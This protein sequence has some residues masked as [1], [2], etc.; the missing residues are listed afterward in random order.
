MIN[1]QSKSKENPNPLRYLVLPH[2]T[3]RPGCCL[4]AVCQEVKENWILSVLSAPPEGRGLM[5]LKQNPCPTK[6]VIQ[7][8]SACQGTFPFPGYCRQ[9]G[10]CCPSVWGAGWCPTPLL[11]YF[12][13]TAR[14]GTEQQISFLSVISGNHPWDPHSLPRMHQETT[15]ESHTPSPVWSQKWRTGGLMTQLCQQNNWAVSSVERQ[16]WS[17]IAIASSVSALKWLLSI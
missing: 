2:L 9:K 3:V 1:L 17:Q 12:S 11:L 14:Y 8:S 5:I 15:Q 10:A 6:R 4:V 7:H 16:M 13:V